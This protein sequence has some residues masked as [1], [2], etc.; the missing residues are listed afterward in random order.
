MELKICFEKIVYS[1]GKRGLGNLHR[2]CGKG[3]NFEMA[4]KNLPGKLKPKCSSLLRPEKLTIFLEH[5][6]CPC[7]LT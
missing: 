5:K 7:L 2:N 6:K 3:G 1:K 4:Y